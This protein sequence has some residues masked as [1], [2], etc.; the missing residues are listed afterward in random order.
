MFALV[1]VIHFGSHDLQITAF[2]AARDVG[3]SCFLI[4]NDGRKI[5][6]DAGIKLNPKS[7]NLPSVGP[8][9]VDS[10]ADEVSAVV[11][12]HAHL[13]HSGYVPALFEEGYEGKVYVTRPTIPLVKVLWEDH[14]GIEGEEH[15]SWRSYHRAC[16]N[17]RGFNYETTVKVADGVTLKF[18]DAGHV[19]G[20]ASVLLDI[21]GTLLFYSGDIQDQPTP[22]HAPAQTPEEPVDVLLLESTNGGRTV[23]PRKK[24]LRSLMTDV[25]KMFEGGKKTI[26]P[27]FAL[28]RS[29]EMQ[30]YFTQQIGPLMQ[31]YPVFVDGMINTMNRIYEQFLDK[32]WVNQSVLDWTADEG[33]DSPFEYDGLRP[34]HKD[35]VKGSVGQFRRSLAKS[36]KRMVILTTSGMME[37]GPVLSYL[38]HQGRP[39]NLLAVVGYQVEDTIG[40]RIVNGE[41]RLDVVSPWG[42]QQRIQVTNLVKRY[43]FSGHASREGLVQYTQACSP[44]TTF[45]IHGDPKNQLA[46]REAL[47]R[48]EL[49]A[50]HLNLD[51]PHELT[52]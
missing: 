20:S 27:S 41:E 22:F 36:D 43:Q 14:L 15:Y 50:H 1:S 5:I 16:D 39:G 38:Q 19:L 34:V 37:G 8:I 46:L 32:A 9:G 26:V 35:Y 21:D 13:D 47:A 10:V 11:V 18:L 3:K 4:E 2:G 33:L 52:L 42:E 25:R 31:S 24:V 12:S 40:W 44:D 30:M 49:S 6:V 29:Q 48:E 17:L 7:K 28:G 51:Q 23:P 45:V